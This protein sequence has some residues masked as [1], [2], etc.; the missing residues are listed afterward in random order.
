VQAMKPAFHLIETAQ[1]HD[2]FIQKC[3]LVLAENYTINRDGYRDFV[4]RHSWNNRAKTVVETIQK[5][6]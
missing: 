5:F 1:T 3:E 4:K 6:L 2:E